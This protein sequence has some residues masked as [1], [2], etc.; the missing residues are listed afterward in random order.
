MELN[1][2]PNVIVD[3]EGG[4]KYILAVVFS[5]NGRKKVVRADKQCDFHREILERLE[6]EVYPLGTRCVGGGQI[7]INPKEKVI[8]IG[9]RSGDFGRADHGIA[10]E[11][12]Q[13]KFPDY[14]IV[15]I[16]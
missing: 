16:G 1:Q 7:R 12:L 5:Y 11:L 14:E 10:K 9:G 4:Y 3:P 13:A 6:D 15:I 2:I 8:E